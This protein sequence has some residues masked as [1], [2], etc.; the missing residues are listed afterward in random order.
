[1]LVLTRKKDEKII[2]GD[3]IV[4]VIIEI[5]GDKVRLGIAAPLDIPVHREEVYRKIKE[6]GNPS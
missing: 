6:N 5:Q 3:D 4:L 1:V 2:I